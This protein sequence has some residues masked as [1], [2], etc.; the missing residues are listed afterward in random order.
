MSIDTARK[1][2]IKAGF[3]VD[4]VEYYVRRA[5]MKERREKPPPKTKRKAS[6]KARSRPSFLISA[7]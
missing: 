7:L 1:I 2:L 6:T 5:Q 4:E 3:P